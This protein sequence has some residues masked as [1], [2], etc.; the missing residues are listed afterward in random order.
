MVVY[1]FLEFL[2]VITHTSQHFSLYTMSIA[3]SQTFL[4]RRPPAPPPPPPVPPPPPPPPVFRS[5]SDPGVILRYKKT[6][7]R[8]LFWKKITD[9]NSHCKT[10]WQIIAEQKY[11]PFNIQS[12]YEL[13]AVDER[14]RRSYPVSICNPVHTS[15]RLLDTRRSQAVAI[16]LHNL[17]H[18]VADLRDALEYIEESHIDSNILISVADLVRIIKICLI[19]YIVL[20]ATHNRRTEKD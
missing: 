12:L 6:H 5:D 16:I 8:P 10:V 19:K 14:E 15:V 17:P 18:G 2:S 20:I 1:H 7:L 9:T 4:P 11:Q 3:E 13:F